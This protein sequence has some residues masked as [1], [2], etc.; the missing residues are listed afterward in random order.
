MGSIALAGGLG[1]PLRSHS[2]TTTRGVILALPDGPRRHLRNT[3]CKGLTGDAPMLECLV[4]L[5]VSGR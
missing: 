3:K 2:R 1:K 4:K 5:L